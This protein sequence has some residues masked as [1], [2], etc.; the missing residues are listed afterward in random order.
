ML[1]SFI[2]LGV[3]SNNQGSAKVLI[4]GSYRKGCEDYASNPIFKIHR[5]LRILLWKLKQHARFT[6]NIFSFVSLQCL[7][8]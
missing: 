4:V 2:D 6:D 8:L 7:Q 5:S 1:P 3:R